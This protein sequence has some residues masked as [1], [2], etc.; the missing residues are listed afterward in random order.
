MVDDIFGLWLGGEGR[1]RVEDGDGDKS[2]L[3]GL[4]IE[5]LRLGGRRRGRRWGPLGERG[6]VVHWG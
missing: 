5:D 3:L 6:F 4:G 2:L 1:A